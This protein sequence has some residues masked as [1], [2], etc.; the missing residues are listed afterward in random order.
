MA[1]D[2]RFVAYRPDPTEEVLLLELAKRHGLPMSRVIGQA[3]RRWAKDE[4]IKAD[5]KAKVKG[6]AD[7]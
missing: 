4:G 5:V 2:R 6:E 7:A 1:T 3:L